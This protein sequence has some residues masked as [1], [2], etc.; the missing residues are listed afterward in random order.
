VIIRIVEVFPAPF[1]PRRPKMHDDGTSI[2]TLLTA[3]KEP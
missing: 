3:V 2:D 1:G